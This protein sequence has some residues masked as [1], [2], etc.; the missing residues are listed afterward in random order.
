MQHAGTVPRTL[1]LQPTYTC[2]G[3]SA[4]TTL[5][6]IATA[7]DVVP[8]T[9]TELK[10]MGVFPPANA[11]AGCKLLLAGVHVQHDGKHLRHR[12]PSSAR[13]CS[14]TTCLSLSCPSCVATPGA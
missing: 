5:P 10:G 11:A 4:V 9:W 14:S 3:G 1:V 13:T 12:R 7:M 8:N 2:V 6:P